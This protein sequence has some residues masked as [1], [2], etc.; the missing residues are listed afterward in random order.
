MKKLI[1]FAL[2]LALTAFAASKT[3]H[4]TFDHDG[5]V[6][7]T[8]IK[9]GDYKVTVDG[10]KAVLKSGK[11]VVE[12]PAK[13]ETADHQYQVS[14][15]VMKTGSD[16]PQIQ[17]IQIGDSKNRIVFPAAAQTGGE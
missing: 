9:A 15:V 4:V 7:A 6:G 17:E 13:L 11:N 10:D 14:G 1:F 5:W 16:K 12:V 3:F 8:E 2:V